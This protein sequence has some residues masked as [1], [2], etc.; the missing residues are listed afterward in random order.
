MRAVALG[1]CLSCLLVVLEGC[2]AGG[3]RGLFESPTDAKISADVRA[4]LA[5]SPALGAPNQISV[6]TRHR[7]VYLTGLV[8]TPY[9]IGEAGSLAARVPDVSTVL[10]RL[11]IDNAR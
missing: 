4:A 5:Q 2:A 10:N 1:V 7:V 3:D 8:S 9:Q 11:S 6:Q